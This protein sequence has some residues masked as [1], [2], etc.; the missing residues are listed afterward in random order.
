[1]RKITLLVLF[2]MPISLWAQSSDL[3][4]WLIYFGDKKLSKNWNWHHEVQYR[5]FNM[6]G[7]MDQ[8]L[9]RTGLG[10]NLTENNNN[11]HLGYAYVYNEEL[12]KDPKAKSTFEENRIYQQFITRQLFDRFAIQHRYRFEQRFLQNDFKLRLRYF[13]S[14]NVA[15]NQLKM[16]DNTV[17]LSAYNEI[18]M[19][20]K[21]EKFD[22]NRVYAGIG[23]MFTTKVRTELGVLNQSTSNFSRNQLNIISFFNF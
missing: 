19:N 16:T 3:G 20:T 14:M 8:L 1:M 11:L 15:L 4:N 9:L 21:S 13:L 22:R 6:L 5:N 2:F 10:Y 17:Y 18:F 12:P 7:D 23:Y